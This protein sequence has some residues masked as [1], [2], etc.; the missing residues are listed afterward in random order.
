MALQL[1]AGAKVAELF[2]KGAL[3]TA[4]KQSIELFGYNF[5]NLMLMLAIYYLLA[6][7]IAK[8]FEA[9]LFGKGIINDI[10]SFIG[11]LPVFPENQF[12]VKLFSTGFGDQ[13]I[14][15]WDL[16][17]S[18]SI[19]LVTIEWYKF[20]ETQKA[21]GGETSYLTHGVF[22]MIVSLLTIITIPKLF[23]TIKSLQSIEVSSK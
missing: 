16:I 10:L 2:A 4:S 5:V 21:L 15:Y 3:K 19:V 14:V 9:I 23:S 6:F 1:I 22:A 8:Y 13:K 11:V 7:F 17:K 20:N 18:L 12:I